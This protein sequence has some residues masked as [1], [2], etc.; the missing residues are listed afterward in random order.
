MRQLLKRPEEKKWEIG[1]LKTMVAGS[2]AG[3][4]YWTCT[5]PIDVVKSRIQ[6]SSTKDNMFVLGYKI[7]RGKRISKVKTLQSAI[8]YIRDLELILETSDYVES[9]SYFEGKYLL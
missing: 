9:Y 2:A 6:V 5:F 4:M 8:K 7:F 3:G 1:P